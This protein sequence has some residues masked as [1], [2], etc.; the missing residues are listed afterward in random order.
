MLTS[1]TE[2]RFKSIAI[3]NPMFDIVF[4]QLMDDD[5][6]VKF[7]LSALLEQEVIDV[8]FTRKITYKKGEARKAAKLRQNVRKEYIG[9]SVNQQDYIA[10]I[11]TDEGEQKKILI[12]ILKSQD[13]E[14]LLQVRNYLEQKH[15]TIDKVNGVDI[16]LP[17]TTIYV[18]WF[19]LPETDCPCIKVDRQYI[20]MITKKVLEV[21]ASFLEGL[22]PNSYVIQADRITDAHHTRLEKLLSIFEQAN[23]SR[24][25]SKIGKQYLHQPD[26][27][28]IKIITSFLHEIVCDPDEYK[29]LE[30]E[31]EAIRIQK[32]VAG[33]IEEKDRIIAELAKEI[34]ER[35][36]EIAERTKEIAERTKEIAERDKEIAEKDKEIA[37][38]TKEIAEGDK[39]IELFKKEIAELKRKQQK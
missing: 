16:V 7:F 12:E 32:N 38:G 5:R 1:K 34:A 14:D 6:I 4:N 25:N 18:L 37:E 10:T 26:D 22:T 29:E 21:K 35:E 31:E 39:E 20:N 30:M 33:K 17:V 36:K 19:D 9:F 2:R 24:E 27:E 23:F 15:K 11:L 28:D 13:R 3:A 8:D